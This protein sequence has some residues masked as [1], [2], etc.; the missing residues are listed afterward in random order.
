MF[1]TISLS[2]CVSIKG[3][4]KDTS[5]YDGGVFISR[6]K[7]NT[8]KQKVLIPSTSG[9]AG[10]F[11]GVSVV[12]LAM[13]PSDNKALYFGSIEAGLLYTYDAAETWRLVQ[14]FKGQTIR[15]VAVDPYSKCTIYVSIGNRVYKSED[16]N[17][18][19][20]EIYRD[21]DQ[22]AVIES[23]T[24]DHENS[25]V[26][27]ISVSR[28]DIIRST[29]AGEGWQTVERLNN[30]IRDIVIDP[31]DANKVYATTYKKGVFSSLNKGNDWS[32]MVELN[33]FLSE[34]KLG[35]DIRDLVFVESEPSVI[36][37]ATYYGLLKSENHGTEWKKINLIMPEK[38]AAIN[39]LAVNLQNGNEIYYVTNTIFYRS[40][41][42][43]ENWTPI[44]L[45]TTRAGWQ[46]L[47]DP[48]RPDVIYLG[49][50]KLTK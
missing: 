18:N 2:G 14:E 47:I 36:F 26:I 6:D 43:G 42:G 27:Y 17:R 34:N 38:K 12:S 35:M 24:I 19:W 15:D 21:N 37:V 48:E 39:A 10:N 1:L 29:N 32:A 4:A 22:E 41:D 31:N 40:L 46:L 25:S 50:R 8:W 5:A 49:L 7:G 28:G 13:D 23:I 11:A 20:R 9:K 3:G 30:R 44:K 45:P 16:C 33:K